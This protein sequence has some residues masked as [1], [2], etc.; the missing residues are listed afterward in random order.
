LA[1]VTAIEFSTA[2]VTV[3]V[4]FPDV[5]VIGSVAVIVVVSEPEEAS[6]VASP[7][8]PA[9]LLIVATGKDEE[10]HVTSDVIFSVVKSE[11]VPVAVNCCVLPFAMLGLTGVTSREVRTALVT[12]RIVVPSI[13]VVGSIA[14]IVVKPTTID[15]ASPLE[16]AALLIVATDPFEELHVTSDDISCVLASE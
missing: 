9:A 13:S 5:E 11:K 15:V 7:L 6:A 8:E 10:L 3:S 2:L 14:L 12:V 1:G 4:V 16:P